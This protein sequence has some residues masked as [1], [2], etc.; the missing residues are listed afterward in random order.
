MRRFVAGAIRNCLAANFTRSRDLRPLVATWHMTHRCNLRCFFC[1][2]CGIERNAR[3]EEEGELSTGEAVRLLRMLSKPFA[4]L[5][6]TGGEPFLRADAPELFEEIERL[7]FRRVAVNTNLTMME[8][9]E[10]SLGAIDELVVSLDAVDPVRFD[11]IRGVPG[12][13]GRVLANLERA[14]GL[15]RERAFRLSVNCVVTPTTIED[16]RGVLSW[17]LARSLRVAVNAQNDRQGPVRELVRNE[18]FRRFV[19]E[20]LEAKRRTRLVLG[21]RRYFERMFDFQ[22]Y[23]C[24]PFLTPRINARGDL[25]WPCD[26]LHQWLPRIVDLGSWEEAV[27]RARE[28]FG[29]VP[30]CRRACQFQCYIEPSLMVRRP[31]MAVREYIL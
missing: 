14:I 22:P 5:Y 26:N 23:A 8:R 20:L 12:M 25:A 4:V 17:C 28:Q 24:Y 18:S 29:P 31:W 2:E 19:G 10:R 13:G 11:A 21:T 1:E 16:A 3:W 27:A 7:P 15:Q 30:D 9:V 6:L